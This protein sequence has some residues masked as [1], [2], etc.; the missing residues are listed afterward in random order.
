MPTEQLLRI[1][2]QALRGA[3]VHSVTFPSN[4]NDSISSSKRLP[5]EHYRTGLSTIWLDSRTGTILR[6]A[7][8]RQMD[9]RDLFL[10]HWMLA[11]LTGSVAGLCGRCIMFAIGLLPLVF[12]L[13]GLYLWVA[14]K[15]WLNV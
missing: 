3:P 9:R 7:D 5:G 12:F 8:G 11:L 4:A 13:T 1:A 6:V 10:Y 14:R 2:D 15:A